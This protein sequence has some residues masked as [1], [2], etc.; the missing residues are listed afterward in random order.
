M[1]PNIEEEIINLP[2]D[3]WEE[4]ETCKKFASLFIKH[5]VPLYFS[6]VS[7]GKRQDYCFSGLLMNYCDRLFWCSA[8]HVI[9]NINQVLN[10]KNLTITKLLWLDRYEVPDADALIVHNRKLMCNYFYNDEFD[11]GIIEI[12]GLDKAHLEN[13]NKISPVTDLIWKNISKVIPDG[14]YIVGYPEVWKSTTLT[15]LPKNKTLVSLKAN[16]ACIPISRL[17][18]IQLMDYSINPIFKDDFYGKLSTSFESGLFPLELKGMSGGPVLSIERTV[19]GK[20]IYRL[21]GILCSWFQEKRIIRATPI[22]KIINQI[23]IWI[24]S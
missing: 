17:S 15:S 6:V 22:E 24:S 16:L 12:T 7:D 21:F 23:D 18:N 5:T 11:F 10:T 4:P 20:L 3:W 1:T 14:F 8:G 19:D 13:N 2:N 9:E